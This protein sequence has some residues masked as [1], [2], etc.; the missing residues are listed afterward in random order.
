MVTRRDIRLNAT[1]NYESVILSE[2]HF[3]RYN[4]KVSRIVKV[5]NT[6][7]DGS[8]AS[9]SE[10]GTLRIWDTDNENSN[11]VIS[12]WETNHESGGLILEFEVSRDFNLSAF[13]FSVDDTIAIGSKTG[14]LRVD[15]R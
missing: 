7:E 6:K 1:S 14:L 8:F 4:N 9:L 12:F 10:D 11:K 15:F 3:N 13:D 2:S 5:S